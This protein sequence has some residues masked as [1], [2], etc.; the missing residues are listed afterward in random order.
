LQKLHAGKLVCPGH[1]A[2]EMLISTSAPPSEA[3]TSDKNRIASPRIERLIGVMFRP[4]LLVVS[5]LF[6]ASLDG[7]PGQTDSTGALAAM[8]GVPFK[9][10]NGILQV[11]GTGGTPQPAKWE[12]LARPKDDGGTVAQLTMEDGQLVGE[13]PSFN[14]G[15]IFREDGYIFIPEIQIDSA[16]AFALAQKQ[17]TA[18]GLELGAVDYLLEKH[19]DDVDP[20]WTLTCYNPKGHKIGLLTVLATTGLVTVQ[21][22][23]LSG[24]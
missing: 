18:V 15:Q 12:I 10:N 4:A 20:A 14:P 5:L 7:A 17:A 9:Y 8:Q 3:C 13:A 1:L 11:R 21:K 19:G 16:A 2:T 22:G 24:Q 6:F 23:F